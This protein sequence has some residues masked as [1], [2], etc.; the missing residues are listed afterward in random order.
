MT[1]S[2]VSLLLNILA[3]TGD[4]RIELRRGKRPPPKK[5]DDGNGPVIDD[6]PLSEDDAIR[7]STADGK[8]NDFR[9]LYSPALRHSM[10]RFFERF[11]AGFVGRGRE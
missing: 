4:T 11:A 7:P 5:P 2:A 9:T 10:T 8:Q 6:V 1:F 3:G